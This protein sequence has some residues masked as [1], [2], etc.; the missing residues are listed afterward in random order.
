M[1][2]K[3]RFK[4]DRDKMGILLQ[5]YNAKTLKGKE[6]AL[7]D[8][9]IKFLEEKSLVRHTEYVKGSIIFELTPGGAEIAEEVK[10]MTAAVESWIKESCESKIK[11]MENHIFTLKPERR[12]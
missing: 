8:E 7:N 6:G 9:S 3:N 12:D 11:D 5:L 10:K 1:E 4:L 2:D